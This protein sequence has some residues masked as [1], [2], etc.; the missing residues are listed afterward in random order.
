MAGATALGEVMPKLPKVKTAV[1]ISEKDFQ[2]EV[3]AE[4]KRLR[5]DCFHNP[6]SVKVTANGFPDLVLRNLDSGVI[7]FLELKSQK[8][9]LR[10]GQQEWIDALNKA[11]MSAGIYRPSDFESIKAMLLW[12]AQQ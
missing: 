2:K 11:G 5:Y 12:G 8:G 3:V 7:F 6:D 9:R 10:P 1:N 4:A